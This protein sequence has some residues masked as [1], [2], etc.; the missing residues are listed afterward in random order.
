MTPPPLPALPLPLSAPDGTA[1]L[2]LDQFGEFYRRIIGLKRQLDP[3]VVPEPGDA[4]AGAPPEPAAIAAELRAH[5]ESR[6]LA[7]ARRGGQ[8]AARSQAEAQ[9][10][11]AGLADEIFLHLV[12]WP[13]REAWRHHLLEAQLFGTHVAGDRIF[14]NIDALLEGND[15]AQAELAVLYLLALSLGFRGR[16]RDRD[17]GG[18]LDD[19]RARLF[20]L[21]F[22]RPCGLARLPGPLSAE[23]Y[24]YTLEQG[25]GGRLRSLRRWL[26]YWAGLAAALVVASF[27]V[28]EAATGDLDRALDQFFESVRAADRAGQS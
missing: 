8:L 27:I 19:Y 24:A 4:A 23:P 10:V 11:M 14:Q 13:G 17:D 22:R 2:L 28:W 20:A 12:E 25:R 7:V 26:L 16:Y 1:S 3:F 18:S 6:A 5:L 15:P 21:V 9:Y